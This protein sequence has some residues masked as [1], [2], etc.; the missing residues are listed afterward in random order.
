M[1]V[2]QRSLLQDAFQRLRRNRLAMVSAVFI[3]L[4]VV[5]A[6]FPA[7]FATH[8]PADTDFSAGAQYQGMSAEHWL[9]TDGVGRDW[10]SRLVYGTRTALEIGIFSQVI[11]LVIGLPLGLLA[12][13]VGGR[14]DNLL[15]RTTDLAYAFPSLLLILLISQVFGPSIFNIFLAIGLVAW[16]DIARLVRAQVLR[17]REMDFVMAA[18]ALGVPGTRIMW[19][20]LMP[21]TAGPVMVA[22]TFGIPAAIFVEASLSF[23]GV[24]L[25]SGTPSWGTMISDGYAAIF[26]APNLVIAPAV[27]LSITLLCFTFLGDGLR[28]ALDPR[29][30]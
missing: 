4:L 25:P 22:V 15:M 20:H 2:V 24:G 3:G 27:T 9:G 14:T 13:F 11:I 19:R 29:T 5:V 16:P 17:L 8:D 23:L 12:G 21:N 6:L 10:Y 28:D 18:T 30:R 26:G 7:L 1:R